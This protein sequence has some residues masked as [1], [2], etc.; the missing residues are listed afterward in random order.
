[1]DLT[2]IEIVDLLNMKDIPAKTTNY[3]L[4][5]GLFEVSDLN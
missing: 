5:G 3:T 4:P 1:M 2:N